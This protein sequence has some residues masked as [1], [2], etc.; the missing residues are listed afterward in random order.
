MIDLEVIRNA[1][2]NMVAQAIAFFP[3]LITTLFILL[4]GWLVSR[5]LAAVIKR[6]ADRVGLEN[7]LER[8]GIRA[9]LDKAQINRSGPELLAFFIFWIIFLNFMLVGLESLGLEAAVEPLRS[10]IA[11]L[12]QLLV[13]LATL[14][15]GILLAQFIGRAT[16][17]AMDGMGVEFSQEIGQGV[18]ALLVVMVMIVVLEQLGID[19]SIMTNII[20]NVVTVVAAGLALAFGLGGR[21]VA[22]NILA[23][24]Y[25]REQFA[26]GDRVII[27]DEEGTLEAIGTL[28]AEIRLGEERL[29]IPN[30]RLTEAAVKVK[31]AKDEG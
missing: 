11:F 19:A 15:L 24:Y 27:D 20:T 21:E 8:T 17:A 3:R 28:N 25:A 18:N 31:E 10:L 26:I 22:R 12:P 1:L 29:I 13:A 4:L 9:G 5:L 30:T 7:L 23:S 16:Q 2:S 6:L 14:T